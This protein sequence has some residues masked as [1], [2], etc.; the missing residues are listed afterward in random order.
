MKIFKIID[1]IAN[2]LALLVWIFLT[3]AFVSASTSLPATI[4]VIA[5]MVGSVILSAFSRKCFIFAL[6]PVLALVLSYLLTMG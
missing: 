4:A 6:L 3:A 1:V 5:L 2:I